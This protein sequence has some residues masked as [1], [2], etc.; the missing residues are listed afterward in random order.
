MSI[1]KK[2][3]YH[4]WATNRRKLLDELQEE[5][6]NLYKGI[7]LD[8]GGRDRGRFEKPK[9]NVEKWI[10]ADIEPMNN[11]DMVLNVED[12]KE[13]KKESI[14]VV[15]AIELF[16]HVAQPEKGIRE[17]YRILKPGGT[18]L[19]STPFLYPIHADPYDYQ[20]WTDVKW[21]KV[22]EETGFSEIKIHILGRYFGFIADSLQIMTN[23]ISPRYKMN[24]AASVLVYPLIC[25]LTYIDNSKISLKNRSLSSYHGGYF[26][27]AS[28]K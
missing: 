28:R 1:I 14:D 12:M 25:I 22:L 11:P 5:N 13:I 24:R 17:C 18:I 15:N 21:K 7:V 6:C 23:N 9:E 3:E 19:I 10:F 8:I 4:L 16:E 20:R 26:I 2:I 27:Y